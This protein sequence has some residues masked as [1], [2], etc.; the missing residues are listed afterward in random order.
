[1][2]TVEAM[3][4]APAAQERTQPND[5]VSPDGNWQQYGMEYKVPVGTRQCYPWN[6]VSSQPF[7]THFV[8]SGREHWGPVPSLPIA[9]W[10]S[11]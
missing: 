8:S 6:A 3:T 9:Q 1:M 2:V 7:I 11:L 10:Q 4:T 5:I